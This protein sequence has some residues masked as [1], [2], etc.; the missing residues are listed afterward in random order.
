MVSTLQHY[1]EGKINFSHNNLVANEHGD[2]RPVILNLNADS[3][4][5][6]ASPLELCFPFLFEFQF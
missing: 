3:T 4:T 2:R 1:S 6:Y 5:Y